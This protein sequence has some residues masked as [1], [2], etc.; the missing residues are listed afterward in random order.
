MLSPKPPSNPANPNPNPQNTTMGSLKC[1]KSSL[2]NSISNAKDPKA[3]FD[4][5]NILG[6]S[7]SLFKVSYETGVNNKNKFF[8]KLRKGGG[9]DFIRENE[10]FLD[11][12]NIWS[13]L[14]SRQGAEFEEFCECIA[15]VDAQ[16]LKAEKLRRELEN[17]KP[18]SFGVGQEFQKVGKLKMLKEKV[19]K[20]IR[21]EKLTSQSFKI[22]VK[23]RM[24][25]AKVRIFTNKSNMAIGVA[26][27][28]VPDFS[29]C[30]V[31]NQGDFLIVEQGHKAN[32]LSEVMFI[33][34]FARNDFSGYIGCIFQGIIAVEVE[35]IYFEPDTIEKCWEWGHKI[36]A[37]ALEDQIKNDGYFEFRKKVTRYN[38]LDDYKG[39]LNLRDNYLKLK[40]SRDD[41]RP[42]KPKKKMNKTHD[43]S[44]SARHSSFLTHIHSLVPGI[45]KKS[46][47]KPEMTTGDRPVQKI[48]TIPKK[49]KKKTQFLDNA[50]NKICQRMSLPAFP[51]DN[52]KKDFLYTVES[53]SPVVLKTQA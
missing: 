15:E 51:L 33:T 17:E 25:P 14:V 45:K 7:A 5:Q 8:G 16:D 27:D 44:E 23:D 18:V 48:S 46:E 52:F 4:I 42:K 41:S 50:N 32:E 3:P 28:K 24:F 49:Q 31:M 36:K 30:D 13:N 47:A 6:G 43:D 26:F 2:R 11:D 9:S 20:D 40:K 29:N 53:L 34:V 19:L 22:S 10:N 39:L 21:V 35:P 12:T 1:A 37:D 38:Y